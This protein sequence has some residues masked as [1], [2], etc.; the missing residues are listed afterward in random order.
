MTATAKTLTSVRRGHILC[1]ISFSNFV[2]SIPYICL[3]RSEL[4][5]VIMT[6]TAKILSDHLS[7]CVKT[8]IRAPV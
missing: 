8:D 3:V 6:L 5:P 7:V 1:K 2:H 4:I